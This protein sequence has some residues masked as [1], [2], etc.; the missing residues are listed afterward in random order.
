MKAAL[1][2]GSGSYGD[3]MTRRFVSPA[4]IGGTGRQNIVHPGAAEEQQRSQGHRPEQLATL[5]HQFK[6]G[7]FR[8]R[9]EAPILQVDAAAEFPVVA[10]HQSHGLHG[11]AG[12]GRSTGSMSVVPQPA[13]DEGPGQE[14]RPRRGTAQG[15]KPGHVE[16]KEFQ[17]GLD[18]HFAA[19]IAQPRCR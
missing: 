10:Q 18:G 4:T 11:G 8:I 17:G 14:P 16:V 6:F 2:G 7:I 9:Q 12:R 15:W 19:I 3:S 1:R 5:V 13:N